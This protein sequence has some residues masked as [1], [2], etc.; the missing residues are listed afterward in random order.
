M[1]FDDKARE[2]ERAKALKS[3]FHDNETMRLML[4][5]TGDALL[6]HR[7]GSGEPAEVDVELMRVR[8]SV[9]NK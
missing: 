6:I 5:A 8:E 1:D 3:K 2:A 4:S 9:K 7:C